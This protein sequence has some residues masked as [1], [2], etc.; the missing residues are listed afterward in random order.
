ML[1]VNPGFRILILHGYSDAVTPYRVSA[2]LIDQ[3]PRDLTGDRVMLR[4]YRVGIYSTSTQFRTALL[5]RML[6]S[7]SAPS[8]R[9]RLHGAAERRRPE[10][11]NPAGGANRIRTQGFVL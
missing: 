8:D 9:D 7:S 1:A 4:N 2:Y 10:S 3:A 6:N 5:R 11:A